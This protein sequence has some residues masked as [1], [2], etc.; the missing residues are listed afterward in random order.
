MT[1]KFSVVHFV[2]R[3]INGFM[4]ALDLKML[5]LGNTGPCKSNR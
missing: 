2:F 5:S 4:C 3:Y 1:I